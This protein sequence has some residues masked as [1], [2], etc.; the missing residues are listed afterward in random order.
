[1]QSSPLSIAAATMATGAAAEPRSFVDAELAGV[2]AGPCDIVFIVPITI[3]AHRHSGIA[4]D[5]P[6]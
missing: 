3:V 4:D 6:D 5:A 1:M 2:T